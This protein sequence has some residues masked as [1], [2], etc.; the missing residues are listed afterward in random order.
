MVF[1][2]DSH[3]F[4]QTKSEMSISL[5][6]CLP[7]RSVR[8]TLSSCVSPLEKDLQE[9]GV[10]VTWKFGENFWVVETESA[11]APR[12]ELWKGGE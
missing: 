8:P 2:F 1:L 6:E 3:P 5:L 7:R 4:T 12:R 9:V 10:S 11:K